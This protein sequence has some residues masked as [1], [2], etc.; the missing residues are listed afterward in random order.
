M[1]SIIRLFG[2]IL[3]TS[4]ATITFASQ[5]SSII[6][7]WETVDHT[8]H[9][10]SS[11]IKIWEHHGK[12]SGKVV[13]T[14]PQNAS[15]V[16]SVC[17]ACKGKFHNKPILGMTLLSGLVLQSPGKY[18]QGRILDPRSGKVY[19]CQATLTAGGQQLKLRG[20]L[21]IPLL[22]QTETWFRIKSEKIS[23]KN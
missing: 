18:K 1:T 13:K 19:H 6:G 23:S 5:D 21:G 2:C 17:H 14:F 15:K 16:I 20:Y 3:F 7:S 4:V 22:G 12:Y 10:I 9:H 8:T 11:I